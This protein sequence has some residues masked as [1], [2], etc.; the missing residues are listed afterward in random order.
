MVLWNHLSLKYLMQQRSLPKRH[1]YINIYNKKLIIR[2]NEKDPPKV[3]TLTPQQPIIHQNAIVFSP[4]V[5]FS[6]SHLLF[7]LLL[8]QARQATK[9]KF[10]CF[11]HPHSLA[12][13]RNFH[14]MPPYWPRRNSLRRGCPPTTLT[15]THF[16]MW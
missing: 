6:P 7:F 5:S 15:C 4:R 3:P 11:R 2:K 9:T 8:I 16:P 12:H 13:Y 10:C 14:T 1:F